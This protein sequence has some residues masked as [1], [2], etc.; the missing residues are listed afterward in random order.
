MSIINMIG[1][2][3]CPDLV[4][5]ADG[6]TGLPKARRARHNVAVGRRSE[7]S[8]MCTATG[9]K[10]WEMYSDITL[11]WRTILLI[12]GEVQEMYMV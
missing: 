7:M 4:L 5:G 2:E 6:F 9:F 8:F 1:V 12:A 3:G 11:C 10:V